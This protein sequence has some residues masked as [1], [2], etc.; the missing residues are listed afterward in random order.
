VNLR[1]ANMPAPAAA[2]QQQV[3]ETIEQFLARGG[4]VQRLPTHWEQMERAA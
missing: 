3:C 2:P 4:R 1:A